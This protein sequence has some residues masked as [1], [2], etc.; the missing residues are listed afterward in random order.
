M[1]YVVL[2]KSYNNA[3]ILRQCHKK[4]SSDYTALSI[5][6]SFDDLQTVADGLVH[7]HLYLT[8]PLLR[9]SSRGDAPLQLDLILTP[10]LANQLSEGRH[11][12]L[13]L[14]HRLIVQEVHELLAVLVSAG[15]VPVVVLV[16]YFTGVIAVV[17]AA[18]CIGS[19][20]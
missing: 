13:Q 11:F 17:V 4:A 8:R 19:S 9:L 16:G 12:P 20:L 3:I 5:L 15:H 7:S 18:V 6:Q 1:I 10:D 2:T 14:A